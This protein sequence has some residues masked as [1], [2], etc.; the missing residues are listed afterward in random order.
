MKK[1]EKVVKTRSNQQ[2][3]KEVPARTRRYDHSTL[4][5]ITKI[6]NT[7]YSENIEETH[8]NICNSTFKTG[9]NLKKH[10]KY[11]HSEESCIPEWN[12]RIIL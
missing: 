1:E 10:N 3:L 6:I 7:N 4:P 2:F 5:V 11:K 9:S 12:P 8:C